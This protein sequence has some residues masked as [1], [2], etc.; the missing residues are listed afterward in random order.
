VVQSGPKFISGGV[1]PEDFTL[2]GPLHQS[3]LISIDITKLGMVIDKGIKRP[4]PNA[5]PER[6]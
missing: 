4:A 6:V 5:M 3:S 1:E 2:N